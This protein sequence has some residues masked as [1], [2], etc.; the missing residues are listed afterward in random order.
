[1][2][3]TVLNWK[4]HYDSECAWCESYIQVHPNFAGMLLRE[5]AFIHVDPRPLAQVL[6]NVCLDL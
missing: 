2:F 4:T 3:S 5:P 1:M 6:C